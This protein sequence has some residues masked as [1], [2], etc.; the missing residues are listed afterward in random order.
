MVFNPLF[1]CL[2]CPSCGHDHLT[3]VLPQYSILV[4]FSSTHSFIKASFCFFY[5]S[6]Q[7]FILSDKHTITLLLSY[8]ITLCSLF[9]KYHS[10]PF[11][12]ILDTPVHTLQPSTHQEKTW[13]IT[14]VGVTL[15]IWS[16]S[17][18]TASYI[19][20]KKVNTQ[21]N[22]T[23]VKDFCSELLRVSDYSMWLL[24][25]QL[26]I[27]VGQ[28]WFRKQELLTLLDL[29]SFEGKLLSF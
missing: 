13:I 4:H 16:F 11:L 3:H 1:H 7:L 19:P 28:V 15:L 14:R 9:S 24:L 18:L 6:F 23:V 8:R 12:Y 5:V 17:V 20:C 26:R 2:V 22:S 29:Q 10:Y 25:T 21:E 27:P